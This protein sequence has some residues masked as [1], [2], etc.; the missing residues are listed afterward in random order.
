[1]S[2]PVSISPY[3]GAFKSL[4]LYHFEIGCFVKVFKDTVFL[5]NLDETG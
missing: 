2:Q 1:M 3:K 4:S 5:M